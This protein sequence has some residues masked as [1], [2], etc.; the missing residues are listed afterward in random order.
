MQKKKM[1]IQGIEKVKR[2]IKKTPLKAEFQQIADKQRKIQWDEI[3][4]LITDIRK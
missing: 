4:K 3:D 1:E 2:Y